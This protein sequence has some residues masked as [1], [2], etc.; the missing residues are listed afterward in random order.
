VADQAHEVA[1]GRGRVLEGGHFGGHFETSAL[2]T[3]RRR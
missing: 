2:A 3:L 1:V